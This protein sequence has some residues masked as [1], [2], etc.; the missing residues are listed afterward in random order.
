MAKKEFSKFF[1][2]SLKR[3]A[4]NVYPLVRRKHKLLD[5]IADRQAELE[6]IEQQIAGYQIPIKEATGGFTTEDLVKREVID[7]GKVDKD[8]RALTITKYVPKAGVLV[9]NEDGGFYLYLRDKIEGKGI[10]VNCFTD[11]P[12]EENHGE[13]NNTYAPISLE[14][15]SASMNI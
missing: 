5:E 8:G 15:I 6:S 4:Q 2:A 13:S 9:E 10:F 1:T 11:V 7:T 12:V 14:E 3:T